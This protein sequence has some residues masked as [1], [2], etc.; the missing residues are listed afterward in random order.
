[1]AF[2]TGTQAAAASE[3]IEAKL[4]ARLSRRDENS[5]I[6]DFQLYAGRFRRFLKR[7]VQH[8]DRV[9]ADIKPAHQAFALFRSNGSVS[10]SPLRLQP[11]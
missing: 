8:H 9:F 5:G 10:F 6:R 7:G 4:Q 3:F 2:G 1:L 11:R